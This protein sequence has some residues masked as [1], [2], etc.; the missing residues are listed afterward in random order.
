[1]ASAIYAIVNNITRDMYVGSSVSLQRRWGTHRRQL[2]KSKHPN[3]HLQNAYDKYGESGFDYEVIEW[4][5]DK[6]LL[7]SREQF[8]IDFFNPSYN[9]QK[10]ANSSIGTTRTLESR[11]KMS[12]VQTGRKQSVETIDKR[13]V[14]LIGHVVTPETRLKISKSHMGIRPSDETR[15]KQSKAKLGTRQSPETVARRM[16]TIRQRKEAAL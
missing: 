13:R 6:T 8:W 3:N 10:I 16:A 11:M 2:R 15:L 12:I 7:I 4:V 14:H 9:K 5:N 1:M